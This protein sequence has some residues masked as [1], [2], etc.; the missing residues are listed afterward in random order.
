MFMTSTTLPRLKADEAYYSAF[1]ELITDARV[2]LEPLAFKDWICRVGNVVEDKYHDTE[3][4][5]ARSV[6]QN[7]KEYSLS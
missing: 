7:A 6:E 4:R 2:D 1:L 5:L 3:A